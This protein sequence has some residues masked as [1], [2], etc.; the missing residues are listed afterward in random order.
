MPDQ[1]NADHTGFAYCGRWNMDN[2]ARMAVTI[3][4]GATVEFAYTG[5]IC[6]LMFD[7]NGIMI[8]PEIALWVDGYGPERVSLSTDGSVVLHPRYNSAL[9]GNPPFPE[10]RNVCHQVRFMAI[11]DSGYLNG[12]DNWNL[13][14][15]ACRFKGVILDDT[16]LL[17]TIS[18]F[19]GT[20]EFLGDSITAGLA[21]LRTT[22]TKSSRDFGPASQYPEGNWPELAAR[23][24]GL[25][26]I[27]C[28]HGGQGV[29]TGGTGNVPPADEAFDWVCAGKSW[30]PADKPRITVIYHGTNDLTKKF[31]SSQ[32]ETYLRHIRS[33]YP[34]TWFF[35]VVPHNNAVHCR[36]IQ[37]A[38]AALGDARIFFLDYSIGVIAAGDTSDG[39]HLNPGGAVRLA[40]RITEDI[41]RYLGSHLFGKTKKMAER[42]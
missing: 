1:I 24:L 5:A 38:V 22:E 42:E 14:Q 26:P 32:Y 39:T 6:R 41:G 15:C 25:R 33:V 12:M 37:E 3:N 23:R 19:P 2:T 30:R 7:L 8:P 36:P 28:G 10:V 11:M 4:N 27:V 9:P 16:E 29:T 20:I 21:M 35:A 17:L 18:S 13:Q 34:E 31:N 40:M